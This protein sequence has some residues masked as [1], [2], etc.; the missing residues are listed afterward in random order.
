[1]STTNGSRHNGTRPPVAERRKTVLVVDDREHALAAIGFLLEA[2]G[3]NVKT[4]T[5]VQGALD[6]LDGWAIDAIVAD[7][8]L[9]D[10]KPDGAALL[11]EA[12]RTHG[13][14]R[15]RLLLTADSLG[16]QHAWNTRSVW[17]DRSER[18]WSDRLI[19]LLKAA[20]SE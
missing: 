15:T 6:V 16:A 17:V 11:D 4:A 8:R 10:G 5:D 2:H 18:D 3:F 7:L 14:V 9:G 1:M 12:R 20:M 13:G 19:E